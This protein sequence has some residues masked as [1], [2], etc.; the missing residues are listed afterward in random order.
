MAMSAMFM[1]VARYQLPPV[2]AL[3]ENAPKFASERREMADHV[4]REVFIVERT[5]NNIEAV[6]DMYAEK[7]ATMKNCKTG[8]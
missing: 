1:C 7:M 4:S 2:M 8:I 6:K 5:V 3:L